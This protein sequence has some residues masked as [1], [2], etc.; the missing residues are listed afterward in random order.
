MEEQVERFA[1]ALKATVTEQVFLESG[2]TILT[3]EDRVRI[4]ATDTSTSNV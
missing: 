1:R 2:D 4:A 3:H